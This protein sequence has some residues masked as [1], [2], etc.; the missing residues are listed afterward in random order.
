MNKQKLSIDFA[1][2]LITSEWKTAYFKIAGDKYFIDV[3][4][5]M[6]GGLRVY[7]KVFGVS[8]KERFNVSRQWFI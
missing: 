5:G 1:V 6:F 3:N 8:C 2:R 7:L 4:I